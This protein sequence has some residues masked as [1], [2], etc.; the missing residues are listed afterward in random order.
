MKQP[1]VSIYSYLAMSAFLVTPSQST[2]GKMSIIE[3]QYSINFFVF[4]KTM[5]YR[6]CKML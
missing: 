2:K 4:Y 3:Q 5:L 1:Q 6:K